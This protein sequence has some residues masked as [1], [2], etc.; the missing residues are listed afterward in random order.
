MA[1]LAATGCTRGDAKADATGQFATAS[2]RF[3]QNATD[4]DVEVV[5]EAKGGDDGL[6]RLSVVSPD[7]RTIVNVSAPDASTLGMRQF[8]FESPEPRNTA[9]LQSA[10]PEGVYTFTGATGT[11]ATL[12]GESRLS[13]KLPPSMSFVGPG[14]DAKGVPLHGLEISWT[15]LN[16][17]AA[18]IVYIE[19][20][21]LDVEVTARVPG[22]ATAFA[23]PDGFLRPGTEYQV[24]LG[25]VSRDG[26]ISFVE[27]TLTTAVRESQ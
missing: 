13:H 10:Y 2:I 23:V 8:R 27:T 6:A 1:G 9:L 7:G 11:G 3:E 22:S 17:L 21:D 12:R 20:H 25:A 4:G 14:A 15:P 24:G 26:N 5:I 16:D 18:C 19:N